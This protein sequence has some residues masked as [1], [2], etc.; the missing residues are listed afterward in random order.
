[1]EKK[2]RIASGKRF[3]KTCRKEITGCPVGTKY[4]PECAIV[5][6]R[7]SRAKSMRKARQQGRI[8]SNSKPKYK[9]H[10]SELSLIVAQ[11]DAAGMSYGKYVAMLSKKS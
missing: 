11:A 7:Q 5:A 9:A 2:K 1:M 3:C 10:D 4:C 8:P 6:A